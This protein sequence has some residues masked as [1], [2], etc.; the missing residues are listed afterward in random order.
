[1]HHSPFRVLSNVSGN[2]YYF[3]DND[4]AMS[5]FEGFNRAFGEGA[6]EIGGWCEYTQ[7]Y[8]LRVDWESAYET[9]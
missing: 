4:R 3:D 8:N 1:M 9:A 7:G 6:A 5:L 2:S